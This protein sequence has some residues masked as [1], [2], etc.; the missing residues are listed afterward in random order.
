M[1]IAKGCAVKTSITTEFP[2]PEDFLKNAE[3]CCVIGGD[4]TLLSVVPSCI[5]WNVPVFGINQGKLGFLATFSAQEASD[6]FKEILE[7]NYQISERSM[8]QCHTANGKQAIA[9]N[10]VVVKS[11]LPSRLIALEV[12]SNEHLVTQYYCDGL[13]FAT[14]TGSTAYN[15]SAGGAIVHPRAKV[16][17]L[18]PICP[19]TLS[20]RGLIL[21]DDT[22][23]RVRCLDNPTAALLSL[24]G[25]ILFKDEP[26]FPINISKTKQP[27]SLLLMPYY[28]HFHILRNKLNWG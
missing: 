17:A 3:A 20:N 13:I 28:S 14:P 19:H 16:L 8:L 18:T 23:L 6:G 9:L 7:G 24:D 27:L 2:V 25:Q 10:D 12:L 22:E 5:K 26:I 4:G 15:L 21:P 11:Q 1:E